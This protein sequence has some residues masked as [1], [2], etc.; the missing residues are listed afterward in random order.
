MLETNAA[1]FQNNWKT[2]VKGKLYVLGCKYGRN[3]ASM[4]I[5]MYVPALNSPSHVPSLIL[6][7]CKEGT[8]CVGLRAGEWPVIRPISCVIHV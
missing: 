2:G 6:G 1:L 7:S 5:D 4:L 8:D 3:G